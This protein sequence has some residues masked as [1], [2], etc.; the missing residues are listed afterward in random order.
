MGARP[1]DADRHDLTMIGDNA[2]HAPLEVGRDYFDVET[3]DLTPITIVDIIRK[4]EVSVLMAFG[5]LA[6]T[7]R[8]I[9][10]FIAWIATIRLTSATSDVAALGTSPP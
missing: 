7:L 5:P 3:P 9:S 2:A 4:G 6:N 1:G 8:S 10:R